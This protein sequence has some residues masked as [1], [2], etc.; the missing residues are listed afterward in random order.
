MLCLTQREREQ[1]K[2]FQT[3]LLCYR[4]TPNSTV[5][6]EITPVDALIG[7]KLHTTLDVLHPKEQQKQGMFQNN[8]QPLSVDTPV[9]LRSCKPGQPNWTLG[10]IHKKK[11]KGWFIYSWRS[12]L[13]TTQTNCILGTLA[14][15]QQ[16]I[17]RTFYWTY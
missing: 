5:K 7:R 9:F 4:T 3:F 13:G 2:I 12:I 8:D 17:H 11:K 14:T 1:Q 6:N 10:T 16:T 15:L